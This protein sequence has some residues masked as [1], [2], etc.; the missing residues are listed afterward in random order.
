MTHRLLY[1]AA[2]L[3]IGLAPAGCNQ[4]K[5][6]QEAGE[7]RTIRTDPLRN[8]DAAKR[9]HEKGLKYLDDG[10]LEK[11]EKAFTRA[12]TADVKYGPAHHNLGK[13]YY[14]QNQWRAAA[15]EFDRAHQFMPRHP[16]PLNGLG[17]V[18]MKAG[19][20]DRAVEYFSKAVGLAPDEIEFRANLVMARVLRGERSDEVLVLL[21][22][23]LEEDRRPDWLLWARQQKI[24]ITTS[25]WQR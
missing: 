15:L 21:D 13:V 18:H 19:E 25:P 11:A 3:A 24:K 6:T 7:Y 4:N 20:Y 23:V 8:T 5:V 14:H 9:Y 12:L 17:L 1:I 10:E 16:D 22:Q 2:L